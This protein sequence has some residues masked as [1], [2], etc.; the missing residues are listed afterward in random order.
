MEYEIVV[1]D[2]F[3]RPAWAIRPIGAP[4]LPSMVYYSAAAARAALAQ[5]NA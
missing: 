4:W 3:G 1:G 5:I 2:E